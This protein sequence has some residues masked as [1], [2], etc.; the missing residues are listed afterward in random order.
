MILIILSEWEAKYR[1][2]FRQYI[3]NYCGVT[4]RSGTQYA[5]SEHNGCYWLGNNKFMIEK[6]GFIVRCLDSIF[7]QIVGFEVDFVCYMKGIPREFA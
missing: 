6:W 2:L 5:T 3:M 1:L 4:C 7:I